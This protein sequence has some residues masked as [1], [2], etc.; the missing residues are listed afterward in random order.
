MTY[1]AFFYKLH[2]FPEKIGDK[3]MTTNAKDNEISI[4]K[5][6]RAR[7]KAINV[8]EDV[9]TEAVPAAKRTYRKKAKQEGFSDALV[10]STAPVVYSDSTAM[11]LSENQGSDALAAQVNG[12]IEWATAKFNQIQAAVF[13][14]KEIIAIVS[15]LSLAALIAVSYIA[16]PSATPT[17]S[18]SEPQ[19]AT[20]KAS[21]LDQFDV[22]ALVA[23]NQALL[24]TPN[25]PAPAAAVLAKAGPAPV[26][27]LEKTL[28]MSVLFL[29]GATTLGPAGRAKALE[30][31]NKMA[32]GDKVD[33]Y[34]YAGVNRSNDTKFQYTMAQSRAMSVKMQL[35]ELGADPKLIAVMDPNGYLFSEPLPQ[36]PKQV[37]SVIR[38]QHD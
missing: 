7:V 18:P 17:K 4:K 19:I 33:L 38:S 36:D 30:I 15:G 25:K 35:V 8:F 5:P 22:K 28:T 21:T 23:A 24:Q 13:K 1:I 16:A 10:L 11:I 37:K 29:D 9:N 34:G 6:A 14:R 32:S 31:K 2:G 20:N 12:A 27:K 26:L 3:Y